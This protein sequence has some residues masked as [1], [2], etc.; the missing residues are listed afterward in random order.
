M[1][2][3]DKVSVIDFDYKR[4]PRR[5]FCPMRHLDWSVLLSQKTGD[6]VKAEFIQQT[7]WLS[8]FFDQLALPTS[9]G[10]AIGA[11]NAIYR[12]QLDFP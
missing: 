4:H 1:E 8:N 6:P 11:D 7:V 3:H 12:K 10:R 5:N 9:R 2:G